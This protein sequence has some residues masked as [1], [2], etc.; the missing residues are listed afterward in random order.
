MPV[1]AFIRT[2]ERTV[3]SYVMKPFTDQITRS[4]RSR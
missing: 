1:E 4:F 3:L 2:G